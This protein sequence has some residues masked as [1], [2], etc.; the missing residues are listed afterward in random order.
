MKSTLCICILATVGGAMLAAGAKPDFSGTWELE[1]CGESP[2]K[3]TSR[4]E[5]YD[6]DNRASR[7]ETAHRDQS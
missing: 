1:P 3:N 5:E 7:A 6:P 2:L 4:S